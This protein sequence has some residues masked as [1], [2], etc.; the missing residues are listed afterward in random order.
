MKLV[1]LLLSFT[2]LLANASFSSEKKKF[3]ENKS[4]NYEI[5][6]NIKTFSG[7]MGMG[8]V[9]SY[10]LG[11]KKF[12]VYNGLEKQEILKIDDISEECPKNQ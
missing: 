2:V 5:I 1:T 6:Q 11:E 7:P 12:C 8:L 4:H 3:K 10:Q 9:K